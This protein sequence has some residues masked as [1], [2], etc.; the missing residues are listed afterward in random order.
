MP[1]ELP[2]DSSTKSQRDDSPIDMTPMIDV[3]FLLII[4]FM[5]V[6][7]MVRVEYE[8][9]VLPK[10]TQAVEIMERP[11]LEVVNVTC[12]YD[13][14]IGEVQS[15][16]IIRQTKYNDAARLQH[17]LAVEA[18]RYKDG[19]RH[20]SLKVRIRA[21]DRASYQKVQQV[22]VA[23]MKAGIKE[24]SFGAAPRGADGQ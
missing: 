3:V 1:T 16:I 10:A 24:V 20:T 14:V 6:S 8:S 19:D 7:E 15:D 12:Q 9:L 13:P 2:I 11:P 21:D 23:C 18:A 17:H 22:M 5:C 4:F